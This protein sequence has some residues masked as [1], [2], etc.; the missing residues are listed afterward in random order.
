[1]IDRALNALPIREGGKVFVG[2]VL[3]LGICAAPMVY[4]TRRGHDLFSQEKPQAIYDAEI[5]QQFGDIK[6]EE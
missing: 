6:K 2:V 1:M 3:G 4:K 5:Q